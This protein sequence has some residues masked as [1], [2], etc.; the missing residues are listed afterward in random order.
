MGLFVAGQFLTAGQ[1]N[2]ATTTLLPN[3][4]LRTSNDTPTSAGTE[5][6]WGTTGTISLFANTTYHVVAE[7]FWNNTVAN[8]E[9]FFRIRETNVAGTLRSGIVGHKGNGGGAYSSLVS[10]TFTSG[11]ATTIVFCGTVLR[12]VGTG[13][14]TVNLNSRLGV[15]R[16]GPSGMLVTA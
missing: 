7:I 1:L 15:Y 4:L 9:P 16:E 10:Y 3:S 2:E 5:K 6:A 13:T 11:S 12:G 8:D 14:I